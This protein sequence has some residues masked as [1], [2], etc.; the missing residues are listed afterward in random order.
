MAGSERRNIT[1]LAPLRKPLACTKK[2]LFHA[3]HIVALKELEHRTIL[4]EKF[5]EWIDRVEYWHVHDVDEALPEQ[6]LAE[7]E[8]NVKSLLLKLAG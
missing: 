4:E 2:I 7:I 8:K 5:P 1:P 6:A 3:T